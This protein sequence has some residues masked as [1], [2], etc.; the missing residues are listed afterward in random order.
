VSRTHPRGVAALTDGGAAPDREHRLAKGRA[1][2]VRTR[3]RQRVEWMETGDPG[4]GG[5]VSGR[6][7]AA[8]TGV[9]SG[10]RQ[11]PVSDDGQ[12]N[13]GPPYRVRTVRGGLDA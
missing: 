11:F 7:I 12:R 4:L 2:C 1:S 5:E 13:L 9:V 8:P 3:W 10:S 6:E